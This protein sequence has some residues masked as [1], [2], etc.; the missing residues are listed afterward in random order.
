[1][2]SLRK[3][4]TNGVEVVPQLAEIRAQLMNA[5]GITNHREIISQEDEYKCVEALIGG[6]GSRN[7]PRTWGSLLSLLRELEKESLSQTI[8]D[9]FGKLGKTIKCGVGTYDQL[10]LGESCHCYIS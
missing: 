7:C 8:E 1:M 3:L 4:E 9:Y 2:S 6:W 5:I 10:P